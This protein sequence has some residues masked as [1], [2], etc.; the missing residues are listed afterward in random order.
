MDATISDSEVEVAKADK[1]Y[2]PDA[3]KLDVIEKIGE[4]YR[5][6]LGD[7]KNDERGRES[8]AVSWK[9]L[10]D[11]LEKTYGTKFQSGKAY[12]LLQGF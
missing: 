10:R 7:V 11:Y 12:I 8:Q 3:Q 6:F 2:L 9:N 1:M 4:N 5:S